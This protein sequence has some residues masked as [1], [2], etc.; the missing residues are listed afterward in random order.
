MSKLLNIP[1]EQEEKMKINPQ[2][3]LIAH[4]EIFIQAPPEVVWKTHTDINAWGQWQPGVTLAKLE[5]PLAVGSTFQFKAGGLTITSTIQEVEPNQRIGWTGKAIGTQA[6]HIWMLTPQPNG[7]LLKTEES[8]EGWLVSL[9]KLLMP[10]FLD[11][12][13]DNWLQSLKNNVEGNHSL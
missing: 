10:K 4:R 9:L 5:G 7:T 13:L 2:A 6:R 12:S 8:M 1:V 11:K 3:P